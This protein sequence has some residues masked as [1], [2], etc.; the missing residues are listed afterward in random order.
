MVVAGAE[1]ADVHEGH[2]EIERKFLVARVPPLADDGRVL[3]QGYLA[4][5]DAVTVRIRDDDGH[6][7][8]TVKGG[9]GTVRTE[10][11]VDLTP[12]QFDALWPL[13]AGR[14]V[15]KV[16]R[17]VRLDHADDGHDAP[18]AEL[19]EFRGV[20]EGRWLVEVEF[21]DVARAAAFVPP[22]WFG[23]DVTDDE[24][25]TNLAL[26]RGGWPDDDR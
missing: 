14:R 26:S 25:F 2:V 10:V 6:H 17:L 15:E 16:R 8:L 5:E 12:V 4:S 9:R 21:D 3:R 20:L 22:E 11:E 1:G 24:R 13:T 7:R 23:A 19:D 18:R